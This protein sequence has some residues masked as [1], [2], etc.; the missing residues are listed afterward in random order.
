[1]TLLRLKFVLWFY[2]CRSSKINYKVLP[3]WIYGITSL[4]NR[5]V[6]FSVDDINRK[7]NSLRTQYCRHMKPPKNGNVKKRLTKRQEWIL[8]HLGFLRPYIISKRRTQDNGTVCNIMQ[9]CL[10]TC[11]LCSTIEYYSINMV[12]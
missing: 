7:M 12:L 8:A 9:S 3:L 2:I 11:I 1:M 5:F 10:M 6:L 4:L